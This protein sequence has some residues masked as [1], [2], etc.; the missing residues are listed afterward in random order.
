MSTEG[1][2]TMERYILFAAGFV[3]AF[4]TVALAMLLLR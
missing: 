3:A 4:S 2:M 1:S